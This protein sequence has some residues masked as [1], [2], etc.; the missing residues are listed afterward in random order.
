MRG[1]VEVEVGEVRR[2]LGL[3]GDSGNWPNQLWQGLLY[4]TDEV[5]ILSRK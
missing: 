2:A 3:Y 5:T 4:E 1:K